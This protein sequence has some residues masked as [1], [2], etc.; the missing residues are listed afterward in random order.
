[1]QAPDSN[2]SHLFEEAR[3][4]RE[5]LEII[6]QG[7][8]DGITVLSREG[9]FI[10]ANLAGAKLCGFPT[11]EA[12]LNAT[13]DQV[14]NSFS[15]FKE[16]GSPFPTEE[17]PGRQALKGIKNPPE[18]VLR[19]ISKN[20][21]EEFWSIVSANP[22][23]DQQGQ[24]QAAVSI[25]RDFTERKHQADL[26]S[27]IAKA[28]S[29]LGSSLNIRTVLTNI[30]SLAV[31]QLAD[32]CSIYILDDDGKVEH[33]TAAHKDPEQT[34]WAHDFTKKYPPDLSA[35]YG[36]GAVLRTGVSELMTHIPISLLESRARNADHLNVL[37]GIGIQSYLAVPFKIRDHVFGAMAFIMTETS[38]HFNQND[39]KWAEELGQRAALSI[40]NAKLFESAQRIN[41]LKDEF[42]ATLSHELRTPLNVILGHSN[43]LLESDLTPEQKESVQAINRQAKIQTQIISDLLDVSS[44]IKGKIQFDSKPTCPAEVLKSIYESMKPIAESRGVRLHLDA[45]VIGM[46]QSDPTRLHQILW[47]LVSNSIKFTPSG[48]EISLSLARQG[49]SGVITVKDTGIGIEPQFLPH[50]F[51]RFSQQDSS[52]TRKHGG[53]GLG[54][55][56]VRH[57]TEMHGGTIDVHSE[58][59]NKGTSFQITLPLLPQRPAAEQNP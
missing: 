38:R 5:Q 34:K 43:L 41:R 16:D 3:P 7:V 45:P 8:A 33:L 13:T 42:L 25:F 59:T 39:L 36:V 22:I 37:R 14:M 48:G 4:S 6:L 46:I 54:L 9:K 55:S 51:E 30:A 32:W 40:E 17:L 58:G 28:A 47:N 18:A 35:P 10:Y 56:I 2:L 12:F 24:V 49:P 44:I 1:M 20:S 50:I 21:G 57:L 29:L 53:L 23:F 52:I 15:M 11:V 26:N 19:V 27:F 31:P